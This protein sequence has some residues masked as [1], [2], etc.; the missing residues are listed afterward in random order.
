MNQV[1][2]N[3]HKCIV[4]YQMAFSVQQQ[5][6]HKIPSLSRQPSVQVSQ[7][8]LHPYISHIITAAMQADQYCHF[9]RSDCTNKLIYVHTISR[10]VTYCDISVTIAICD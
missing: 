6:I 8:L 4:T 3:I 9:Q 7:T 5:Y 10:T 2:S 1:L